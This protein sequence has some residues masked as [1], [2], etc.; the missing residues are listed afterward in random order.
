M[1]FTTKRAYEGESL[2]KMF[3]VDREDEKVIMEEEHL[4]HW[5]A[6]VASGRRYIWWRPA[7]LLPTSEAGGWEGRDPDEK[8]RLFL[9]VIEDL[10]ETE[11]S[12]LDKNELLD[13]T[14]RYAEDSAARKQLGAARRLQ[15]PADLVYSAASVYMFV[16]E[17]WSGT[18]LVQMYAGD[19]WVL[20]YGKA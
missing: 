18:I 10:A 3:T 8:F 2:R 15:V 6:P 16:M 11:G 7:H 9:S 20:R 17:E 1:R 4:T 19:L 14:E 13:C 5:A 12:D